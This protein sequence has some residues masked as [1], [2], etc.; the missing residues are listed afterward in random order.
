MP[1]VL[2]ATDNATVLRGWRTILTKGGA[3]ARPLAIAAGALHLANAYVNRD[4]PRGRWKYY[5][6]A[7]ASTIAIIPFTIVFIIPTNRELLRLE[8]LARGT[9][10]AAEARSL[11]LVRAWARLNLTRSVLPALGALSA[12]LAA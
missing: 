12:F 1:A 10:A 8:G 4:A 9:V 2:A 5:A 6:S 3:V 11:D 7:A